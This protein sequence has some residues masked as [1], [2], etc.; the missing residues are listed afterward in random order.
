MRN[1]DLRKEFDKLLDEF[2]FDVL[3]SRNI[4]HTRCKC[5]DNLHGVGK[6]DCK[7]CGGSGNITSLE[8]VKVI[9][10]NASSDSFVKMT[11][12]GLTIS[13]TIVFYMKNT[14]IPNEEDQIFVVGYDKVGIP[15]D[16]K[17]DCTIISVKP[18]RGD[19]GR[20]ELYEILAKISPEK[21]IKDQKRLNSIKNV[22]K[23]RIMEGR[24]FV[25]TL[26]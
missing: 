10:Q 1:I 18:I 2:G 7:Y 26:N 3:M 13:N 25:W 23:K 9:Y 19:E 17:E 8:K 11:E 20:V 22:T 21:I 15:V 6:A 4:K 24:R 16:I 12:L 5:F 14:I